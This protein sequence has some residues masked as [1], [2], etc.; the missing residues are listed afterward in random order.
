MT[1]YF[2]HDSAYVDVGAN[3]GQGTKIW[4]FCHVFSGAKIGENCS[5]GQNVVVHATAILGNGVKIQNNVSVYD[6]VILEDHVFCG[7]SIVFT[8]VYNPR[9]QIVR[10]NEY[11]QTRVKLGAT[12][13]ANATIMCGITIGQY[14]FI[15]A[16][17]VVLKNVPD[18]AL[19]VGNPAVQKGW[20]CKCGEKIA[21]IDDNLT[22]KT[23]HQTYRLVPNGLEMT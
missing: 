2:K 10:K 4:H 6:G 20:M 9:S 22:C 1:D 14:A 17:S 15:G 12:I 18:H 8:N 11:R 23:C 13:G 3:I 21:P 5:L 7:P 16:G 19:M